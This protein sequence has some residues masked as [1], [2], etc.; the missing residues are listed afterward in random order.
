M[1]CPYHKLYRP[2]APYIVTISNKKS[3]ITI[4]LTSNRF[5]IP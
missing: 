2:D 3:M 4:T 1:P 5:E